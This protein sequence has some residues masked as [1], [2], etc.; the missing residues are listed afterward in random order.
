[1]SIWSWLTG[2]NHEGEVPNANPPASVGA[3]TSSGDPDGVVIEASEVE[4]R[5]LPVFHPPPWSG[6][7]SNW[8][9]QWDFGSRF[10]ELVDVAWTCLDKNASVLSA[11]P[12]Y[13]T[14]GGQVASPASWMLNPDPTIYTSWQ[15]F[16]K[17]LFWDFQLGEAFVMEMS[18]FF[19]GYPMRFR[20]V[21]PWAF[22][23]E[24]VDGVRRYR[25]G[26]ITGPDVT[27]S[28]LHIRYKSTSDGTRGVGALESAGGRMLTAGLLAKYVREVAATGGVP[29]RTIETDDQLTE[30]DAADLQNQ[31]MAS[32]VQ[33]SSAPPVFDNAAKL[34]DHPAV[35][36]KDLAMIELAQFNESRI[37]VLLGMPPFLV[38]LP[39]GGDSMTYSN[40]SGLFD[41]HDR[42]YLR[43]AA[44]H[45]MGALSYWALPRG[46]TAEL[47]RDEYSRPSFDQRA[48][49]WKKLVEAGV[50]TPQQVA[51]YER[52]QGEAP[53]GIPD[54]E[55]A[56]MTTIS[57]GDA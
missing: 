7:P 33:N 6:W 44:T 10:N 56:A 28:V 31:Y 12:V 55:E 57:G 25:L 51:R 29:L 20:V 1:L 47:N 19:D 48:D 30:D 8:S 43:T 22:N 18:S 13:R 26:G 49:A 54:D 42:S 9:T 46:Q 37:A 34:V 32:R 27:E 17:Q 11:M 40:V 2:V 38:G 39:S 35:S 5:G 16:A 21:P 23:V 4:A 41:F 24:F 14:A 36:P 45:V 53:P 50:V 3:G 15:E 52:F